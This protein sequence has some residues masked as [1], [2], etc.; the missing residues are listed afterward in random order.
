MDEYGMNLL[1]EAAIDGDKSAASIIRNVYAKASAGAFDG[2][3]GVARIIEV[4]K[5][6][7]EVIG[8]SDEQTD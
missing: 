3:D 2:D 7:I 5:P 1:G 8:A 4:W 6:T